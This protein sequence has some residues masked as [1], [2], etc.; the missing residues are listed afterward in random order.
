M[1]F[2]TPTV[3][4]QVIDIENPLRVQGAKKTDGAD[5]YCIDNYLA[6]TGQG[7]RGGVLC[8]VSQGGGLRPYPGLLYFA[9][10]GHGGNV[11]LCIAFVTA[12]GYA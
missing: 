10:S 4:G 7:G 9:L 12:L 2:E 3:Q 8:I 6:P 5:V 1:E 11:E